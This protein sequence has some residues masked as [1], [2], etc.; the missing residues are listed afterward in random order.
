MEVW[1]VA[2]YVVAGLMA[3][4]SLMVLMTAHKNRLLAL[5]AAEAER[6]QREERG[7]IRK[8]K[9]KEKERKRNEAKAKRAP[10]TAA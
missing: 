4:R 9:E 3:M 5:A 6:L 7:R 2:L 10:G 8:E 1:Q